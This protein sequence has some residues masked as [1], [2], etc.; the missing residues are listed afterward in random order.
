MNLSEELVIEQTQVELVDDEVSNDKN[1]TEDNNNNQ[2][3]SEIRDETEDLGEF[4]FP[5]NIYDPGRWEN[6]DTKLRDLLVEKGPIRENNLIFPKDEFSR[7]FSTTYY[8]KKLPNGEK[9]NRRWLV[10]SKDFDK[11]YYFCCK[12][13]NANS[14]KSQLSNEE[15][16]IGKT[17]VLNL[18]VMKPTLNTS[19]I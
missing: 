7:H 8:I 1:D 12:L 10:Y 11:V 9:Y 13:F 18:K 14:N 16:M 5:N 6:I 19:L 2:N 15:L 3:E 17:L 4:H